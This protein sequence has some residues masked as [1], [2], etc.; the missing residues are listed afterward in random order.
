MANSTIEDIDIEFPSCKDP[1][2]IVTGEESPSW[3]RNS[4]PLRPLSSEGTILLTLAANGR[5]IVV[6]QPNLAAVRVFDQ[7]D[8]TWEQRGQ[9][10]EGGR[11]SSFG[12]IVKVSTVSGTIVGRRYGL[13]PLLIAISSHGIGGASISVFAWESNSVDWNTLDSIGICRHRRETCELKDFALARNTGSMHRYLFTISVVREDNL[14]FV[15]RMVSRS[16]DH[17]WA[18]QYYADGN[19]PLECNTKDLRVATQLWS[20]FE[21]GPS[22][23][24]EASNYSDMKTYTTT[25]LGP[26]VDE[27][28]QVGDVVYFG[29]GENLEVHI[30]PFH[31][32][33][34]ATAEGSDLNEVTNLHGL[35]SN[36]SFISRRFV[37]Y[38]PKY[39][40]NFCQG[41]ILRKDTVYKIDSIHKID[42]EWYGGLFLHLRGHSSENL[43]IW[44]GNFGGARPFCDAHKFTATPLTEEE[45]RS[46]LK[47]VKYNSEAFAIRQQ[48]PEPSGEIVQYFGLDPRA[49]FNNGIDAG[50]L[51]LGHPLDN[52]KSDFSLSWDGTVVS[53][54]EDGAVLSY[55]L[56]PRCGDESIHYRFTITLGE[57]AELHEAGFQTY[58]T[59]GNLTFPKYDLFACR[60]GQCFT[61]DTQYD[62]GVS[63]QDF[64][65]PR[66]FEKCL[67]GFFRPNH[68]LSSGTGFVLF[69]DRKEIARLEK[70][71]DD[72][73]VILSDGNCTNNIDEVNCPAEKVHI[74]FALSFDGAPHETS[75][76]IDDGTG[77]NLAK[78]SNYARDVALRTQVFQMCGPRNE[79]FTLLVEDT[80][81]D[82]LCC[83]KG[84]GEFS[85]YVDK[86]KV[87]HSIRGGHAF[88]ADWFRFNETALLHQETT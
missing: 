33:G 38:V 22:C 87:F 10:I 62:W 54:V 8:S 73:I 60:Q 15:Y 11:R 81:H 9:I 59:L 51:P 68:F 88:S 47:A 55:A 39:V 82:G 20:P 77:L 86:N 17:R 48:K 13:N 61:E 24:S 29:I 76:S 75:W 84:F 58:Q 70:G 42:L 52:D 41:N 32:M 56:Y 4:Q 14:V 36:S 67:Q 49:R 78:G 16:G 23:Y 80:S 18:F 2:V 7:V 71:D 27:T 79:E 31:S 57:K 45:A 53:G 43:V 50:F 85:V 3:I 74:I 65:I 37:Y 19:I 72:A 64:C 35:T 69:R 28:G 1:A 46:G 83:K 25:S 30:L 63:A 44:I 21:S 6:S 26:M 40:G 34:S 12:R 5:M 66:V